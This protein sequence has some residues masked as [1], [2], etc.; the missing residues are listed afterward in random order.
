MSNETETNTTEQQHKLVPALC[1]DLDGTIRRS[2]TQVFIKDVEDIELIPG[3][4]KIIHKY[5]DMGYLIFGISNQGGVAHG[6]KSTEDINDEIEATTNLFENN[7]FHSIS[8][9]F[10]DNK[11]SVEP[12][13]HRS[14]LRKPDIGML[15]L[16]ELEAWENGFIVDWDNS[17]FVGDR[18]EDEQCA[19]NAGISFRHADEFLSGPHEFTV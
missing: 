7:P 13:N 9:C 10:H 2:K 4:E 6:F 11:G 14:L 1:L 15:V 18:P 16:A 12:F 5:K 17:L 8:Y 19:K 3:I